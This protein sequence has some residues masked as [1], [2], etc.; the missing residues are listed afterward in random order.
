M[1]T[2]IPFFEKCEHR[3]SALRE[4][5]PTQPRK[6]AL[7][8]GLWALKAALR[9]NLLGDA[10][11]LRGRSSAD[12]PLRMAVMLRG[13]IGDEVMSLAYV[14]ELARFAGTGFSI[15]LYSAVPPAVLESICFGQPDIGSIHSI[16]EKCDFGSYDLVLD[17]LR[18]ACVKAY[19]QERIGRLSPQLMEYVGRLLRFQNSHRSFY[20]DENQAMGIH[21]ADVFGV[22][23]RGQADFDGT[24]GVRD[25][26]FTLRTELSFADLAERFGLKPGYMLIQ[27]E[28]GVSRS[29]LKL[30]SAEK[31]TALLAELHARHPQRM[32]VL[33]GVEKNFDIPPGME[34]S[35]LDL[36][37]RTGFSEFTA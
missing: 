30:W 3:L 9:G 19:S 35:V 6:A 12:G 26:G 33:A 16:K 17:V 22:F 21:Y 18:H 23:R 8:L 15:D 32:L 36:R 5:C 27:R 28:A 24:L 29:S 25:S 11:E 10:V 14:H 37:G 2:V 1:P 34:D 31:Y 4:S 7:K 20:T 13:G